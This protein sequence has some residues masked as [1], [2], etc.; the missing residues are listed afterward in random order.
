[1]GHLQPLL[2]PA[3]HT[4][5]FL[6]CVGHTQ[7]AFSTHSGRVCKIL[8]VQILQKTLCRDNCMSSTGAGLESAQACTCCDQHHSS[9][10]LMLLQS[11]RYLAQ[12]HVENVQ[13]LR[14]LAWMQLC[15]SALQVPR[16]QHCMCSA[17]VLHVLALQQCVYLM[18]PVGVLM[19][20]G[21][22]L[23]RHFQLQLG[24][25]RGAWII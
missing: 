5:Q 23:L 10:E 24:L 4:V 13:V 6:A 22:L 11:L 7:A 25:S 16:L 20:Q 15:S 21:S 14:F 1:M 18:S 3:L 2:L 8:T 19:V 12:S 17:A 9:S